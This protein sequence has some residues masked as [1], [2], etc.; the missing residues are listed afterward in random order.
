MDM[1]LG[2]KDLKQQLAPDEGV[3]GL[4]FGVIWTLFSLVFF[5]V[6]GV[7]TFNDWR[8][9]QQLKE[10]GQIVQGQIAVR[11]NFF[12]ADSDSYYLTYRYRVAGEVYDNED[13]VSER[14]YDSKQVGDVV[15]ILYDPQEP[16]RAR[17]EDNPPVSYW[18]VVGVGTMGLVFITIGL[19]ALVYFGSRWRTW[20]IL[21]KNGRQVPAKIIET[22]VQTDSDGDD[23]YYVAYGF[24]LT[25]KD[26]SQ[27]QFY[28]AQYSQNEN[29][30]AL[31]TGD[32]VQVL[33]MMS[34]PER[35][36]LLIP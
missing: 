16:Q 6:A 30:H 21:R 10:M 26:G 35:N 20:Q 13:S 17:L 32:E 28:K 8:T 23:I 33:V 4:V 27:K 19:V 12:D 3:K 7:T 36:Y 14:L 2:R 22:W 29:Y 1:Y 31:R 18:F 9:H 11:E 34:D 5:S 24:T 25:R 15:S